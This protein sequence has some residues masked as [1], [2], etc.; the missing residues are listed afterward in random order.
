MHCEMRAHWHAPWV[1]VEFKKEFIVVLL[2]SPQF[3]VLLE[4]T[5]QVWCVALL[6]L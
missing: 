4:K 1:M 3:T 6:V 5:V 2:F